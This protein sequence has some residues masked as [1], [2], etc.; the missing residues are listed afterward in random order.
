[1]ATARSLQASAAAE[2]EMPGNA[3][4]ASAGASQVSFADPVFPPI[5]EEPEVASP[6]QPAAQQ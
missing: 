2:P 3:P 1:M 4:G 6:V 5:V